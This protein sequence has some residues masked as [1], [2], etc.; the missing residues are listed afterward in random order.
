MP[1]VPHVPCRA[2][3][4]ALS[5]GREDQHHG[6]VTVPIQPPLTALADA[7]QRRA[8][9]RGSLELRLA[10]PVLLVLGTLLVADLL[11]PVFPGS[12]LF[13]LLLIPVLIAATTLGVASGVAALVI[14]TLGAVA[15]VVIRA[16]PWLSE[17][18]DALRLVPYLFVG[19]FIVLLAAVVRGTTTRSVVPGLSPTRGVLIEP[20][21]GREVDVLSL[22]ASGL[23]TDAIGERLFLS[24]N[25]VKSHLHHAYAKLGAHN[26]VEAIAAG[27]HAGVLDRGSVVSR[28]PQ[29]TAGL[30]RTPR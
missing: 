17:P 11:R 4:S 15:M 23:S 6:P 16:H 3:R 2:G 21:T 25:T 28:A 29:I 14:G 8:T 5:A 27:L 13:L 22:A 1:N 20:L 10:V 7:M 18:T 24:P 26:R 9:Y 19:V 30:T 12:G